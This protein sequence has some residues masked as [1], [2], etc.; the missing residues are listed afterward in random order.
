MLLPVSL[1]S[2]EHSRVVDMHEVLHLLR[3]LHRFDS[4][5]KLSPAH[6]MFELLG[7]HGEPDRRIVLANPRMRKATCRVLKH[8][9][10]KHQALMQTKG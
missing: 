9:R 10:N 1:D 7:R 6:E 5:A 2:C 3:S 4:L 8:T